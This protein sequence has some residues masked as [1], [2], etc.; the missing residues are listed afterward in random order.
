MLTY[1][2]LHIILIDISYLLDYTILI[3]VNKAFVYRNRPQEIQQQKLITLNTLVNN[4]NLLI[5]LLNE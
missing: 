4:I 1:L 2:E 5:P 3:K